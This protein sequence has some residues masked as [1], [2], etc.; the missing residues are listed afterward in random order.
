MRRENM[1]FRC[2][3]CSGG[4]A[5]KGSLDGVV[6]PEAKIS[7]SNWMF[8]PRCHHAGQWI[9]KDEK[10]RR[11]ATSESKRKHKRNSSRSHDISNYGVVV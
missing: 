6:I 2:T 4:N 9:S 1:V 7:G 8:C 10:V 11:E 5:R 3:N